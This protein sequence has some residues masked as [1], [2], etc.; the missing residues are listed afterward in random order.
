MARAAAVW[1]PA[2]YLRFAGERVRPA[3]D[4]LAQV[5]LDSPARVVDLGCG[6]GNVTA[7][8]RQRFPHADI[9]G[10]DGSPAMLEKARATVADCRF[11]Q[12]GFFTWQPPEPLDLIYTNAA[13]QW[14]DRH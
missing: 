3:L 10:M 4:L 2:Q 9:V 13:L 5:P 11:E 8:L 7:I 6:A 1:D 14:V 12:G